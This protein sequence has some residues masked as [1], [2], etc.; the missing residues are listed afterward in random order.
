[1]TR[2]LHLLPT[3]ARDFPAPRPAVVRWCVGSVATSSGGR[4]GQQRLRAAYLQSTDRPMKVEPTAKRPPARLESKLPTPRADSTHRGDAASSH[5]SYEALQPN[6]RMRYSFASSSPRTLSS[7]APPPQIHRKV[8]LLAFPILHY[9]ARARR[10]AQRQI[11]RE[12]PRV[13]ARRLAA[14][15]AILYLALRILSFTLAL[16]ACSPPILV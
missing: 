4:A 11:F 9:G 12:Q 10:H 15:P 6:Q 3:V 16:D 13:L 1:M 5:E 14:L 8:P 2:L 7:R